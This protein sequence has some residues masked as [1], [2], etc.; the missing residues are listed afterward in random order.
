LI[1]SW[2]VRHLQIIGEA[3]R[4]IPDATRQLT[5]NVPWMQIIGMRHILVHNYFGVDAEAVWAVVE[6]ELAPS[7]AR[8]RRCSTA[9]IADRPTVGAL[10][11]LGLWCGSGWVLLPRWPSSLPR[12]REPPSTS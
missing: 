2:I 11:K 6:R 1:Q 4:A 5:P 10:R 7:N 8:S 9:S 12:W 3:A